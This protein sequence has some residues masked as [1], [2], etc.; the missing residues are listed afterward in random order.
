MS[1]I[2]N[3]QKVNDGL[4]CSGQPHEGQLG[5]IVD[6]GYQVVINLGLADGKYALADEASSIKALGLTY[7]HIPVQ[8]DNPM[9][10][11]LENFIYLMNQHNGEKVLVHCAANYRA[12]CFTGLY[13]FASHQLDLDQ[14]KDIIEN[15]WQPDAVWQQF[16]DDSVEWLIGLD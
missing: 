13:L 14:M 11:E 10:E 6:E 16:I 15:V 7:H 2:Y 3:F 4:A 12:S 5:S 8:F 1:S 9:P